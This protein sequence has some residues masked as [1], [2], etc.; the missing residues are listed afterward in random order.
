V[1]FRS[2]KGSGFK[3]INTDIA[4]WELE[5]GHITDGRNFR[6]DGNRIVSVGA[7]R[8]LSAPSANP[9]AGHVRFV[10]ADGGDFFLVLGSGAGANKAQSWNGSVWNDISSAPGAY[11]GITTPE[12]WTS[13]MLG[14]IPVV[15]H[16]Q[17]YPEYWD[18]QSATTL[19]Q[20][21]L[22]DLTP[23]TFAAAGIQFKAL[24]AYQ[25]YLFA[26]NLLEG[27]IAQPN[28]YRWSHPAPVNNLP[29]S[30]DENDDAYI[31][32]KAQIGGETGAIVDGRTIRESF[33]IYSE[34]GVTVLDQSND[35]FIW[36]PRPLSESY[37]AINDKVLQEVKGVH[38][39]MSDGDILMNDG[40]TIDSIVD[41]VLLKR[42]RSRLNA[43]VFLRN[44]SV[45]DTGNKELWFFVAEGS[46]QY[47]D[48]A[49]VYN[50][51]EGK[52]S[53]HDIPYL[54]DGA[55]NPT[56]YA[57]HACYGIRPV[58]QLTWDL[59]DPVTGTE[60]Y[61]GMTWA[62][63]GLTWAGNTQSPLNLQ[64]IGLNGINGGLVE[65]D[66]NVGTGQDTDFLIERTD[67]R[68][69]EDP[70]VC[71]VTRLYPHMDSSDPVL[72]Q[73]GAQKFPG[74]PVAWKA[75]Q[76][77]TPGTDRK[78]DVLCTGALFAYRVASIGTG[79]VDMT[80]LSIEYELD[81]AR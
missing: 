33:A 22:Y 7:W 64:V 59:F 58:E 73:I 72:I 1:K 16:P 49:Y 23:T 10:R 40:N 74:G 35:E 28:A 60:P 9:N 48:V 80:G 69:E 2:I 5:P 75:A 76:S 17:H 43:N 52:W 67:L 50:W 44:F 45:R 65:L 68:I 4:P 78:L 79:L 42:L 32:G 18:P 36:K 21:L 66:P 53:I 47:P 54:E 27:G 19:L 8:A 25:N 30:W 38:F 6:I 57:A 11:A 62:N 12:D 77:F 56:N 31:A 15:S 70:N 29:P 26:L 3:G 39:F 61:K 13:V 37:G 46:A 51:S 41:D 24:R 55:G 71:T 63:S 20:P 81:G 34:F 14:K